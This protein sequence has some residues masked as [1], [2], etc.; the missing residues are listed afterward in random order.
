M[1]H[2]VHM[3]VERQIK[4]EQFYYDILMFLL[5]SLK[6]LIVFRSA[7]GP[8]CRSQDEVREKDA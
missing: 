5:H 1:G 7:F 3:M 2:P 8:L 6:L 4:S